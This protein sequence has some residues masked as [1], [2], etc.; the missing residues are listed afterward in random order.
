MWLGVLIFG[1]ITLSDIISSQRHT[2][3]PPVTKTSMSAVTN[4]I[5]TSH[6]I[7]KEN[8]WTKSPIYVFDLKTNKKNV[9]VST[10]T[11]R[12]DG[13]YT[14]MSMSP[15]HATLALIV[16]KPAPTEPM[17]YDNRVYLS[18][19]TLS[20]LTQK[21][22]V[23]SLMSA[24]FSNIGGE[25][26]AWSPDGEKIL[27][28][29]C[30]SVPDLWMIHKDG[31]SPTQVTN[32]IGGLYGKSYFTFS[33]DGTQVLVK[34]NKISSTVLNT[35]DSSEGR[36][37]LINLDTKNQRVISSNDS[38]DPLLAAFSKEYLIRTS[39]YH[40]LDNNHI[41][42]AISPLTENQKL[43]GLWKVNLQTLKYERLTEK[44]A[45][46]N[47]S[48]LYSPD[49]SY[50]IFSSPTEGTPNGYRALTSWL[51]NIHTKE[52]TSLITSPLVDGAWSP[53]SSH[54]AFSNYDNF[55]IYS[56]KD[57]SLDKILSLEGHVNTE[58]KNF[59]W[60]PD[61]TQLVYNREAYQ[62]MG[63][64]PISPEEETEKGIWKISSNG[65]N[66]T[67]ILEDAVPLYW[68]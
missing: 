12:P 50:V 51:L 33:L 46:Q 15:D 59:V 49:N 42:I 5:D 26:V 20:S 56:V 65:E 40:W 66:P 18:T 57:K 52:I 2:A 19:Y 11:L 68:Y 35:F 22:L 62:H 43:Q 63:F 55:W 29:C 28:L 27:Y 8:S 10:D 44:P 31:T 67:K 54:F 61:S 25:S 17:N 13:T 30:T 64:T 37:V 16:E 4:T 24:G 34:E 9:L 45:D 58:I 3:F 14:A 53:N 6:L 21:I 38:S 60:S 23:K 36:L 47:E 41:I 7:L 39:R 1:F 32:Y 48:I